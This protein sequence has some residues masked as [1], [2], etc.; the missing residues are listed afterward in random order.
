MMTEEI[1]EETKRRM[2]KKIAKV[3]RRKVEVAEKLEKW[4]KS[5]QKNGFPIDRACIAKNAAAV[6]KAKRRRRRRKKVA[7]RVKQWIKSLNDNGFAI[8]RPCIVMAAKMKRK[9]E[10][11][12]RVEKWRACIKRKKGSIDRTPIAS[13]VQESTTASEVVK[14]VESKTEITPEEWLD[15]EDSVVVAQNDGGCVT[16][17]DLRLLLP[18]KWFNDEVKIKSTIAFISYA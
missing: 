10:V 11:A 4:I 6:A 16:V 8:D 5:L 1:K 9:K 7:K 17:H 14:T 12:E 2:E 3:N 15:K 18:K 13:T